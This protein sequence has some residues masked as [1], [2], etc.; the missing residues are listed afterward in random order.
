MEVGQIAAAFI[1]GDTHIGSS[2][3]PQKCDFAAREYLLCNNLYQ[4]NAAEEKV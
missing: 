3:Q 2:G 4:L 1:I